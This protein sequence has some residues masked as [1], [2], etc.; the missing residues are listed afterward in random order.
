MVECKKLGKLWLFWNQDCLKLVK[1]NFVK[2]LINNIV[3]VYISEN[4]DIMHIQESL[5]KYVYVWN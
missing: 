5:N 2:I 4:R 1:I 3:C